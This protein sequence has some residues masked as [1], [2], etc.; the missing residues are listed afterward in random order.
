MEN[1]IVFNIRR[2]SGIELLRIFA[3]FLIIISHSLPIYG[4]TDLPSFINLNNTPSSANQF[5]PILFEHFGPL[6]NCIFIIC[7]AWFL[8]DNDNIK[9]EKI[10]HILFDCFTI[11]FI[12]LCIYLFTDYN[13]EFDVIIKQLLPTSFGNNW[14]IGCYLL[15]YALHPLLNLIINNIGQRAHLVLLMVSLFIYCII[16]FVLHTFKD[17]YSSL[18]FFC[19]IYF[20]VAYIKKYLKL[21]QNNNKTVWIILLSSTLIFVMSLIALCILGNNITFLK[22]KM[23]YWDSIRNPFLLIVAL[24]LFMIFKNM[25]FSSHYVNAISS[26]SLLIYVIH[27]NMLLKTFTKQ[28][29]W[30]WIYTNFSY[31]L[32][33]IWII[34][35]AMIQAVASLILAT[36][37]KFTIKQLVDK[38]SEVLFRPLFYGTKILTDKILTLK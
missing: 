21:I 37:Y 34:I 2:Q 22:D 18:L 32:L 7:S 12:F 23:M 31:D 13:I 25:K 30:F 27:D 28:D 15:M 6:G 16:Y 4:S 10:R 11:S 14:F 5:F 38:I 33:P 29:L 26:L 17:F 9:G 3:M 35:I 1:R 19:I 20:L 36:I 8:V 24:S